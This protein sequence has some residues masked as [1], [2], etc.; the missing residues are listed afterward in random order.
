M[1]GVNNRAKNTAET[2]NL[3]PPKI[4]EATHKSGGLGKHIAFPGGRHRLGLCVELRKFWRAAFG[5]VPH[6]FQA[7]GSQPPSP[8]PLV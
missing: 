3:R 5:E 6:K 4:L 8:I 1:V 7:R 2:L